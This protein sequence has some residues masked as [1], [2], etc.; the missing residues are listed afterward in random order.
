MKIYKPKTKSYN[1]VSKYLYK[2]QNKIF[3]SKLKSGC[4]F[5]HIIDGLYL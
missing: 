2:Y 3:L 4:I 1:L 5:M